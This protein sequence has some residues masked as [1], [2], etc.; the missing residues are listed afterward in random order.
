MFLMKKVQSFNLEK[1]LKQ[2]FGQVF[3]IC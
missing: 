3:V 1:L 2:A